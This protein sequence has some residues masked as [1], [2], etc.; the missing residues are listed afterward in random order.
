LEDIDL[1]SRAGHGAL[2]HIGELWYPIRLIQYHGAEKSWLVRWWRGCSFELDSST[3]TP[4]SFSTLPEPDIVD[5]LWGDRVGR[6]KIRISI[7]TIKMYKQVITFCV[8][9][10]MDTCT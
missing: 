3:I 2:G 4:R 10:E 1:W 6:W 7:H 5:S 8:A 9:R